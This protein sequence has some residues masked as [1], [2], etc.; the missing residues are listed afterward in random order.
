MVSTGGNHLWPKLLFSI[1]QS[2]IAMIRQ[3]ILLLAGV[4][5]SP[6]LSAHSLSEAIQLALS[7][8]PEVLSAQQGVGVAREQLTQSKAGWLPTVDLAVDVGNEYKDKQGTSLAK[9]IS[10]LTVTQPLFDGGA[11]SAAVARSGEM[12]YVSALHL[13][14]VRTSITLKA[15]EAWYEVYRLQ[16]VIKL[17]NANVLE[18]KKH[19]MQVKQKVEAGG[20][21]KDEL[22][23]AET[24][25]VASKTTLINAQGDYRDAVAKYVA[26]V[27]LEPQVELK[28]ALEITEALLPESVNEALEILLRHNYVLE[29]ARANLAAAKA[30]HHGARAGL[31]PTLDLELKGGRK[32]N[33]G[34]AITVD[35]DYTA[36]LKLN[37]NLFNGGADLSRRRETARAM[38]ESQ[39]QLSLAQRNMEEQLHQF[40]NGLDVS[41]KL[42]QTSKEQLV[43]AQ[44]N[45]ESAKEQFKLGEGDVKAIIAADDAL[46]QAR[47]SVL[48]DN[49]DAQLGVYRIL[50]HLGTLLDHIAVAPVELDDSVLQGV[51]DDLMLVDRVLDGIDAV[52]SDGLSAPLQAFSVPEVVEIDA[53]A[54]TVPA[55]AEAAILPAQVVEGVPQE[56]YA[57]MKDTGW[58]VM[59][60][61][62]ETREAADARALKEAQEMARARALEEQ[63]LAAVEQ[64]RIA[65]RKAE[66]R[67]RAKALAHAAKVDRIRRVAEYPKVSAERR[68]QALNGRLEEYNQRMALYKRQ[69]SRSNEVLN[70]RRSLL[71][72]MMRDHNQR[73]AS[74][75]MQSIEHMKRKELSKVALSKRGMVQEK[76]GAR[77]KQQ[78]YRTLMEKQNRKY[79]RSARAIYQLNRVAA[80][81]KVQQRSEAEDQ[82]AQQSG[83]NDLF[84]LFSSEPD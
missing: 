53:V 79:V 58:V 72:K 64:Q 30:D 48:E 65:D 40:W 47:K 66:D 2:D 10:S 39:E 74:H 80:M 68:K 21:G 28:N 43:L 18:H 6:T 4:L 54:E 23:A 36:L 13:D 57:A 33:D 24:P 82:L 17:T 27:G 38:M 49:I 1:K 12:E 52:I 32:E 75:N 16:R 44:D 56:G 77:T 59:N 62:S 69:L 61:L 37:Y 45:F 46:L 50:A 9:N 70:E 22:S 31:L 5:L 63:R 76:G 55:E 78:L 19:F 67:A 35:Q 15:I 60:A 3:P 71:R 83:V 8:H 20:A 34:G 81:E 29:T 14:E 51:N 7:N 84:D 73:Q 11:T 26:I 42:L 41:R 25:W